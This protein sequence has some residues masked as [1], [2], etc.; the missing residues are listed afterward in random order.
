MKK[1]VYEV[2]TERILNLLDEG[3]VPW[4][5]PWNRTGNVEFDWPKNLVSK[6]PYSGINVFLL[7]CCGFSSPFWLTYKCELLHISKRATWGGM[8]RRGKRGCR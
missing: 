6:R 1:T 3:T 4:Q 8:S 5:R 2:I 7:S